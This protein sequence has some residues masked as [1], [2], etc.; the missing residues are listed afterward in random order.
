MVKENKFYSYTTGNLP[1]GCRLCVKGEKLVLFIT[2]LCPRRCYFCPVSDEK[3]QKDVVYANEL[4]ARDFD[5]ILKESM[6]MDAKGAGITGGDPLARLNRTADYIKKL[7]KHF[8]KNFHIHLY[9][10]L[11]LVSE[12]SLKCLYSAGLDEIR[13]HLD[14]E[15]ERLWKNLESAKKFGWDV[16][17]EMPLIPNKEKELKKVIDFVSDKVGFLNLNE[18]EVADNSHSNLRQFN[19]H[20]KNRTSYAVKG[21]LEMGLRLINYSRSKGYNIPIHLCTAKL[22]DA[23]QLSNRIKREA[24]IVRHDFDLVDDEGLLT[25]GALYLPELKPG[26]GYRKKLKE[27]SKG[28]YI[29][30]LKHVVTKIKQSLK[31]NENEFIIDKNKLRILLSKKIAVKNKKLFLGMG[32]IPA[33]VVE[34]PTADQFEVEIEFLE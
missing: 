14:L 31:L 13:F 15:S 12:K 23:V 32:L 5:D 8:G 10:S 34:Y 28:K 25:R 6:A 22:K 20:V 3:Y 33:V 16:G 26:F 7:K 27:V 9:T 24:D 4:V 17:V 30:R 21:S 1:Q 29:K 2:G 18:L 11:D 19:F